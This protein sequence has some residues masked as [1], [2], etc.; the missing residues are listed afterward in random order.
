MTQSDVLKWKDNYTDLEQKKLYKNGLGEIVKSLKEKTTF[1]GHCELHII[2]NPKDFVNAFRYA[3]GQLV[4]AR[5]LENTFCN[6]SEI[7]DE[8]CECYTPDVYL[9]IDVDEMEKVKSGEDDESFGACSE[10]TI[11]SDITLLSDE[12]SNRLARLILSSEAEILHLLGLISRLD[13]EKKMKTFGLIFD[14]NLDI[15]VFEKVMDAFEFSDFDFD[16]SEKIEQ[17]QVDENHS[18]DSSFEAVR[19]SIIEICT[20]F[21]ITKI[22]K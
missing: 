16:I 21:S 7:A 1:D 13:D 5:Y 9:G 8:C 3:C 18:L 22:D 17:F 11:F 6:I 4:D 14:D 19:D 15:N 20:E 12:M 10:K 2:N